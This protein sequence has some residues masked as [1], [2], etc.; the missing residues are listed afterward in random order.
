M[1]QPESNVLM[2]RHDGTVS[3][4]TYKPETKGEDE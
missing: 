2:F 1:G 4:T 3:T